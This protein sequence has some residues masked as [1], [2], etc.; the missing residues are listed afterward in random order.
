MVRAAAPEDLSTIPGT[1]TLWAELPYVAKHERVRHLGDLLLR[2]VRIGLLTPG[3][4]KEHLK[5]IKKLCK[6]YLPW[7]NRRW[8]Q[9]IKTYLAQ[10]NHAHALTTKPVGA[11]PRLKVRSLEAVGDAFFRVLFFTWGRVWK[12]WLRPGDDPKNS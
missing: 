8:R 12:R 11:L 9:E 10:W 6:P 1:Q 4:G 3:G 2:R 7:N 5:R